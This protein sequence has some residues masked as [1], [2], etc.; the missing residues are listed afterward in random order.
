MHERA[1]GRS[2]VRTDVPRPDRPPGTTRAGADR[3]VPSALSEIQRVISRV[4]PGKVMTYGD[5]AAAAG[6][7]GAAR[8]TVW[9]LQHRA[10]LP[11]HRIV[12]AGGRIALT[13]ADGWE[14]RMRLETEGVTFRGDR[15]RME[16]HRWVPPSG[17]SPRR[18][19]A[20][21]PA[22]AFPPPRER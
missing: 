16:R 4:P 18:P 11:W 14:Q 20:H 22:R 2:S 7:P 8:L 17:R 3:P 19:R 9:A 1:N 13:G 12:A 15:V 6:H 21:S 10:D 5:A